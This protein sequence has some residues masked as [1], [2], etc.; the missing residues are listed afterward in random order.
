[1]SRR[2]ESVNKLIKE[3]ISK[4]VLKEIEIPKDTLA[5]ITRV[6]TSPD[7]R[8]TKI[9]LSCLPE[10]NTSKI[11]NIINNNIYTLQKKINQRLLMKI[12]PKLRFFEEKE[13]KGAAKIEEILEKIKDNH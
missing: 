7:L 6:E 10:R 4:I 2:I 1:L 3:E 9:Y 12:V 8:D 5:T 11:L 13:T